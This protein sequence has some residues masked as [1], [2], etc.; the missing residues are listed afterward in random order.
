[1]SP[2]P[3]SSEPEPVPATPAPDGARSGIPTGNSKAWIIAIV[4]I[5]GI[6]VVTLLVVLVMSDH[7]RRQYRQ[8]QEKESVLP[9]FDLIKRRK[10]SETDRLE[11]EEQQRRSIIRKSLASRSF[12]SLDIQAREGGSHHRHSSWGSVE[13]RLL[14]P[15]NLT[16]HET[17]GT[18][19][20]SEEDEE[21]CRT[22]RDDWKQWEARVRRERSISAEMHPAACQVP[23]LAIP[24]PSASRSPNR[25]PPR[26]SSPAAAHPSGPAPAPTP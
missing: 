10:L 12:Q 16:R 23:I 6:I 1:M 26:S 15:S 19:A 20:G 25:S 11:E 22:L 14:V 2:I 3:Q 17:S 21:E 9:R 24:Q 7:K 8:T 5:G 18:E 13:S 4:V